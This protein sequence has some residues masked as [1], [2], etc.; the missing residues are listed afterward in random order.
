MRTD[1]IDKRELEHLLAALTAPNRLA[2]EISLS[3][4]LRISDVLNLRTETLKG[5]NQRRFTLREAKTGKRRRITLSLDLYTRALSKAGKIFVFE[6]R[7][8]WKQ[9]RTRQAV[10][11]DLK[12]VAK[13]FRLKA[14]I[15]PHSARKVYAV[16]DFRVHGD[17]KRVQRLLNHESEAVTLV[18][19]LA[20]ELTARKKRGR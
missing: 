18:Y 7:L 10:F 2:L 20:D 5:A 11:K 1:Y 4:G 13:I 15:A 16:E 8:D 6:N 12:R 14:N 17:L 3:T 19:A 9:P